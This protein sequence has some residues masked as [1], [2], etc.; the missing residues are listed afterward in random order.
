MEFL[1][2]SQNKVSHL[3]ANIRK[4]TNL[5]KLDISKNLVKEIPKSL[6]KLTKLEYLDISHNRFQSLPCSMLNLRNLRIFILEWF[7][8]ASPQIP[9][10][11]DLETDAGSF[12]Y[13]SFC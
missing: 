12:T 5:K 1:C 11:V 6:D 8:Y 4:L 7:L 9:K 2:I 10:D 13:E 3:S